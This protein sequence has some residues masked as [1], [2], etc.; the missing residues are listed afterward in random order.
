M[1]A[2]VDYKAQGFAVWQTGGGCMAWGKQYGP[3][4]ALITD[5]GGGALPD[6]DDSDLIVGLYDSLTGDS[7][8]WPF[9][10]IEGVKSGHAAVLLA[11][12][13]AH[14]FNARLERDSE[15]A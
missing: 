13:M 6:P 10:A 14:A 11:D 7:I 1:R 8:A 15:Y 4:H 2:P 5:S 3:C 9:S 12:T